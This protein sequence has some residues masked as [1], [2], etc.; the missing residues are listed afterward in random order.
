MNLRD[1]AP[2]QPPSPPSAFPACWVVLCSGHSA[3]EAHA[4]QGYKLFPSKPPPRS[5]CLYLYPHVCNCSGWVG[6]RMPVPPPWRHLMPSRGGSMQPRRGEK[7]LRYPRGQIV[8]QATVPDPPH[9]SVWEGLAVFVGVAWFHP[10]LGSE[11]GDSPH[12]FGGFIIMS[13]TSSSLR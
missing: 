5:L 1:W 7:P 11:G 9:I 2:A 3:V 13:N 4:F 6:N 8:I 10:L 12:W